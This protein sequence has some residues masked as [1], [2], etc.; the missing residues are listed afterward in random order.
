MNKMD[1][2]LKQFVI[3]FSGLKLGLHEYEFEVGDLFFDRFKIEDVKNGKVQCKFSLLKREN[4]LELEFEF[5]GMLDGACDRC[6][7][8]LEFPVSGTNSIQVKFGDIHSEEN[9]ELFVIAPEEYQID[10]AP[11][12]Y[13]FISLQVPLRKVHEE[14]ECNP[15]VMA[16]LNYSSTEDEKDD[17]ETPSVWDKLKN[18]K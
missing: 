18:L 15:E 8:S 17:N 12:L 14:D 11:L 3:Q 5:N 4:G 10:I 16:R 9:D 7:E 2:Y 6:L 13:E 1:G